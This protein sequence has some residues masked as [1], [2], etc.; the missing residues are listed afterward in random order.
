[1]QILSTKNYDLFREILGNRKIIQRH[2][3]ELI[4]SIQKD[5][6]L[7][8][9]PIEVDEYYRIVDGQH[10]LEAAKRLG[11]DI[12]YIR[13]N[14]SADINTVR[15]LQVSKMWT[16]SDYLK[17]YVDIGNP[18]YIQMENFI[19]KHNL[20]IALG[21]DLIRRQTTSG[22]GINNIFRN[23]AFIYSKE[24]EAIAE[25][26]MELA[27]IIKPYVEKNVL[28][29]RYYYR[30]LRYL[31]EKGISLKRMKDKVI[32]IKDKIVV[33]G[34]KELYLRRLEE[35]YNFKTTEENKVR[36]F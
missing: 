20:P 33:F 12:Y 6:K 29:N 10:R 2:V 23:G 1:M 26:A 17:S 36:L 7:A 4:D 19:K 14:G 5:N 27:Q 34:S 35:I 32:Q 30:A 28:A 25:K 21:L 8:S 22:S 9:H 11:V 15:L 3:S 13:T 24:N 18:N 31:I 16:L